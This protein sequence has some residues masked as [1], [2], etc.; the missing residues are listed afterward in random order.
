VQRYYGYNGVW[1][2]KNLKPSV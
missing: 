1:Y 2:T